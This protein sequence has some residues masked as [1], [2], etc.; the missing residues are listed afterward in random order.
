[1]TLSALLAR[2]QHRH[3]ASIAEQ[4]GAATHGSSHGR[5]TLPPLTPGLQP[6]WLFSPK[7]SGDPW[8]ILCPREPN[9]TSPDSTRDT[10]PAL[11]AGTLAARGTS[12][13]LGLGPFPG[14]AHTPAAAPPAH[15]TCALFSR[16]ALGTQP[17]LCTKL[18]TAACA[19]APHP[20]PPPLTYTFLSS[21]E[22][23]QAK[24][25]AQLAGDHGKGAGLGG[26]GA[27]LQGRL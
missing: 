18:S 26:R 22:L 11:N 4:R 15:V 16:V 23:S 13:A 19:S 7:P 6:A 12:A 8:S 10:Q 9:P 27:E 24:A 21:P 3:T 17:P 20:S 14:L 2:G 1:M 25:G 5:G